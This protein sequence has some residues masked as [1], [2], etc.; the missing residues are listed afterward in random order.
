MPAPRSIARFNKHF[1]TRLAKITF[2]AAP[3]ITILL[4]IAGYMAR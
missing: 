1:T 4:W 2:V 3:V